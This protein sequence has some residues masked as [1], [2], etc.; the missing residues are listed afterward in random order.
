MRVSVCECAHTSCMCVYRLFPYV[1]RAYLSLHVCVCVCVCVPEAILES[2]G[3]VGIIDYPTSGS[4]KVRSTG[5][6]RR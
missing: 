4:E 2:A 5:G 6:Y 3:S 1:V